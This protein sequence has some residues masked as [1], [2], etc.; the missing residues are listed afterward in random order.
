MSG[1]TS[2]SG[3]VTWTTNGAG[4]FVTSPCTLSGTGGSA[5][6]SVT[7]TPSSVGTGSHLITASYGGDLNFLAGN[8]NQAV[9]INKK[10]ASVTPDAASKVLGED[11]PALTGS[12]VGFM[13][14][15]NV[16]AT[17]SRLAGETVEGSPYTISA[18]L[19]PAEVL[20]NYNLTYNTANFTITPPTGDFTLTINTI[21]NGTVTKDPDK[22][23]YQY[24][25]IVT[26]IVTP[27]LGW[28]F[29]SW[30]AN[31][32]NGT[33]TIHGD[34]TVTAT[35]TQDEYT[36]T[37][38]KVGNG[39]VTKD[40]DQATYHYG[41]VVTLTA[42][43]DAGWSFDSWS[44][45]VVA[46]SVTIHTDTT[47][48]ATFTEGTQSVIYDDAD[49]AW[50]YSGDWMPY[51][52]AG[53]YSNTLHYSATVGDYAE[54]M[55]SGGQQIKLTYSAASNRGVTDVY[56]DSVKVGSINSFSP[57][58]GWL[59]TWSSDVLTSDVHTVRFVH[60]SGAFTDID[61]I[62]VLPVYVPPPSLLPGI[63]DDSNALWDYS[64]DWA[65]YTGAGPY[66]NTLHYSATVGDYA[67][68][69][70]SGGQQIKLTYSA[71]SNRGVT[72][73]Y[74]DS[75]KVGSVDA[76][77]SGFTWQAT[78]T[79]DVLTSGL[80]T[81]RLVH[82]SGDFIDLDALELLA[83][84]QSLLPGTADDNNALWNY[85]GDWTAWTGPGPS[86]NTLHYSGTIGDSAQILISGGQQIKLT[87]LTTTNRGITDVYI[88]GVKVT[89]INA[90]APGFNWQV[91][92]SSD[93][94]T[95]GFHVVRLVHASGDFIDLDALEVFA[96]PQ[97]LQPGTADDNNALW[98]YSGD[99][100]VWTGPGPS[101]NTL[102]YSGTI[103]D[104]A[105][106]LI[107]GGQQIKLTYLTT[108]NRGVTDVYIDGVKVASINAYAPGFN[109]Q[110]TWSSDILS[111]G[112]HTV[113]LVHASGDFIDLDALEV[114]AT[115]ASLQPGIADDANALWNYNGAWTAWTGAG[116]YSDTFHYSSAIG[117]SAQ[118]VVS[119][120][121][122]IKLT[123]LTAD[124]RG[125]T[126]VYIDGVKVNS[127]DA[128]SPGF[129]W[130]VTWTSGIL[131]NGLHTV[132]LVHASGAY[133]DLDAIEL[134]GTPASLQPGMVADD[135]DALW[136]YNGAWAT[137][138][139]T[140][141]YADTLHYSS[142][143]GDSAQIVVGNG[144][145]VR[146]TYLT[147]YNRGV[148]DVYIDGVKVTSLDEYDPGFNWQVIWTSDVM[149]PGV[150]TVRFVHASGAYTDID[151]IEVLP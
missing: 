70:V 101:S 57:T 45:N 67:E 98:N 12:L 115:P 78:W 63:A 16:T 114:I 11:D 18:T 26:L 47:V 130:Q 13:P 85:S 4:S 151:A 124:N 38:D 28:S 125:V 25:D 84:P 56:V 42:T 2:P 100:T 95:S 27:D 17:Y 136:S 19:S 112:F 75:I 65:A 133:T 1:T 69:M 81:L 39:T 145:R 77:F 142:N 91:T 41:D 72:D 62:E 40:P 126:D 23:T 10:D 60:A 144:Q 74:V 94:L 102:H 92:W 96:E 143:I 8:G 108:T 137:L 88:D 118:I 120:G 52:G 30:S 9:T 132:R 119:G 146:F 106:I 104:S 97:S 15:D 7:Y 93:V 37:I 121:Q 54:I 148:T 131:D 128:Y 105:Q 140:G 122:Q 111:S 103:G 139:L 35:F 76:H 66:S 68:I 117:D 138:N 71:A 14:S 127:I 3:T 22:A 44:A 21:G 134:I 129:N 33:V 49:A 82:A 32:V 31:V 55:I 109:W 6:C 29:G 61:A 83:E 135:G 79:S 87:Y 89:S 24:G 53:P 149:T 46:G 90:Y 99:W 147:G 113:R 150:H 51:T 59:A 116:P 86:S 110:V 5:T 141:P 48:T 73:V 107:S 50:T 20:G 36:L 123:Y 64:G 58:F 43:P 80:H 34:T